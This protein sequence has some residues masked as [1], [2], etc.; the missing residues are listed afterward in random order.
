[1]PP[2]LTAAC[3]DAVNACPENAIF[4]GS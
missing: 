2:R 4:F 1:V 3:R